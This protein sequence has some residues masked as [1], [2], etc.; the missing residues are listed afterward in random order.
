MTTVAHRHAPVIIPHCVELVIDNDV[1]I[2]ACANRL[3]AER[4]AQLIDRHGLCDVPDHIN[5][6][7]PPCGPAH[8]IH[9]EN[10]Q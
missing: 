7:P 9:R 1:T 6:W 2:C 10:Q 5:D 3:H 8:T 4:I